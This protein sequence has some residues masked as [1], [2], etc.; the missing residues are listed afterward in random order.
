MQKCVNIQMNVNKKQRLPEN[1]VNQLKIDARISS[2]VNHIGKAW[3]RRI[4]FNQFDSSLRI[5][6]NA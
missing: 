1:L 6:Q 5:T 3:N 4:Y 2:W